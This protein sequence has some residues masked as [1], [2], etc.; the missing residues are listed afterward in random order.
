MIRV[1]TLDPI[2]DKQLAKFNRTLYTAFG[3]GSEHSGSAEIPAG[4]SEPLDAE[5]LVDAVKG[6]RAYTDDKVLLLTTRKLKDRELPSGT[7]PT[8][9]FARQ[10]KDRAVLSIHPHKD[11][12]SAYKGLARHALHQLGHLWELHHC[13]DPRCSMYPPWTPSFSQGEPI[14]CTFC[15]E[16]SEQKIRLAKS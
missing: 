12:E 6:I 9:G 5:K 13:L 10:G 3:V 14:F 1:V 7:A 11:L 16:K 2:D 15:R 8:V 4:M